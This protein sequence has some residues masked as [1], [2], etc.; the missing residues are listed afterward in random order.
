MPD[1]DGGD[2]VERAPSGEPGRDLDRLLGIE[3]G[4]P[5]GCGRRGA[6]AG[7]ETSVRK[8]R[9][10][11]VGPLEEEAQAEEGELGA[12]L[13]EEPGGVI[14]DGG[15]RLVNAPCRL[16]ADRERALSTLSTVATLTPPAR[17][18]R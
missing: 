9:R 3:E 16:L 7:C 12:E 17:Q 4:H 13:A 5:A 14:A 15:C 2:G 18:G 6:C 11:P 8:A 1:G 10:T